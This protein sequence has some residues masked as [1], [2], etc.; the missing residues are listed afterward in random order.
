MV[1]RMLSRM[2]AWSSC[3]DRNSVGGKGQV[4]PVSVS[5]PTR[6]TSSGLHISGFSPTSSA[7]TPCAPRRRV[8]SRGAAAAHACRGAAGGRSVEAVAGTARPVTRR[9]RPWRRLIR[10]R[11]GRARPRRCGAGAGGREREGAQLAPAG[12]A[13]AARLELHARGQ[14]DAEHA[15]GGGAQHVARQ[16]PQ[17][18]PGQQAAHRRHQLRAPRRALGRKRRAEGASRPSCCA[19]P[20]CRRCRRVQ[21]R[22][23]R[24]AS[25]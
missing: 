22:D 3:T 23:H 13:G 8:G 15:A 19:V 12:R 7:A 10:P 24:S 16:L 20:L 9:R 11:Y 6:P 4:A 21:T 14:V 25:V 17:V 18:Q 1:C 5:R 2:T